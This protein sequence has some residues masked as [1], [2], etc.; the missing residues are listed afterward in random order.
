MVKQK[1]ADEQ[2]KHRD[3]QKTINKKREPGKSLG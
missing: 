1:N 3:K 2:T